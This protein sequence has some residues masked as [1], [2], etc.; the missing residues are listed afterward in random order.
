MPNLIR[1]LKKYKLYTIID[2]MTL[3][4]YALFVLNNK[5]E[6]PW[7]ATYQNIKIQEDLS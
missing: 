4:F 7:A 2:N 3:I 5:A 1:K 6:R